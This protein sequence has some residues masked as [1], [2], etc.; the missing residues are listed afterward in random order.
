MLGR[1]PIL[2]TL[3][4]LGRLPMLGTLSLLGRL[5]MLRRLVMFGPALAAFDPWS[6]PSTATA[7][8]AKLVGWYTTA[9]VSWVLGGSARIGLLPGILGEDFNVNYVQLKV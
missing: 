6:Q 2:V 1:L 9:G 7:N 5:V 3:P 4:M 8:L